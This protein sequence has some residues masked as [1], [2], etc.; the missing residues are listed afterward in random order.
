[1]NPPFVPHLSADGTANRILPQ[2]QHRQRLARGPLLRQHAHGELNLCVCVRVCVCVCVPRARVAPTI[3]RQGPQWCVKWRP[4]G[5]NNPRPKISG[6]ASRSMQSEMKRPGH[7]RTRPCPP[8]CAYACVRTH[9][10]IHQAQAVT[11]ADAPGPLLHG[12]REGAG[13]C[14]A[15]PTR[16]TACWVS[17]LGQSAGSACW[18]SLL[19]QSARSVCWVSLLGQ[20]AG[21][22][23]STGPAANAQGP[24]HA[25]A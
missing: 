4:E 3:N 10:C 16:G 1:M 5:Q 19:G 20:S 17:L 13:A 7:A 23:P 25:N 14:R 11:A 22:G 12:A 9:P 15:E 21:L 18:V 24:R 8:T 6:R 2:R